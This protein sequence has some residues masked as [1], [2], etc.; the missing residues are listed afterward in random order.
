MAPVLN[1]RLLYHVFFLYHSNDHDWV[2]DVAEKLEGPALGFKCCCMERDLDSKLS[3]F[4]VTQYGIHNSRKTVLVLSSDF[5][6][7][8]WNSTDPPLLS[9]RDV[10]LVHKDLVLLLMQDCDIPTVLGDLVY[11]DT[12]QEDWWT[13][14]VAR[15]QDT[16]ELMNW[17]VDKFSPNTVFTHIPDIGYPVPLYQYRYS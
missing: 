14:L 1:N 8:L 7:E 2:V 11:V 9:E 13:Q 15:L 6:G 16:R 10:L 12:G 3:L 17:L 5:V 4:Q